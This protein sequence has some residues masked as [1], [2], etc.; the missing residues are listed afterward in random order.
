MALPGGLR[1]VHKLKRLVNPG[2]QQWFFCLESLAKDAANGR[3]KIASHT[4]LRFRS[5]STQLIFAFALG[6]VSDPR[7]KD[8][9]RAWH[10]NFGLARHRNLL[11][12]L[13]IL[14]P[15]GIMKH[16]EGSFAP[17]PHSP[18]RSLPRLLEGF[19]FAPRE[20]GL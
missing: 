14:F 1:F 16:V 8:Q 11:A 7:G 2:C 4:R 3:L 15:L 13:A 9:P 19:F 6:D 5:F 17:E 12:G 10:G 20:P 18:H